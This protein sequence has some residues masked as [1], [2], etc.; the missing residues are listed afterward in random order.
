MLHRNQQKGQ[1]D[2]FLLHSQNVV[3]CT[4]KQQVIS[5]TLHV[6]SFLHSLDTFILTIRD[7]HHNIILSLLGHE[8]CNNEIQSLLHVSSPLR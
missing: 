4:T 5:F 8:L 6:P 1:R 2:A 7:V 3:L